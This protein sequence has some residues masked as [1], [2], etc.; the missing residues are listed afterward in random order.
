ML[1][2]TVAA[3]IYISTDGARFPFLLIL[4]PAVGLICIFLMISD[5]KCLSCTVGHLYVFGK[6]SI[7]SLCPFFN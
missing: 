5:I 4:T 7:Q 6:M 2:S 1:F 3:P